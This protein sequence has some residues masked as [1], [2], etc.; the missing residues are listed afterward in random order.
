M[1]ARIIRP[2]GSARWLRIHAAVRTSNGRATH[3]YGMK[4]DV[5]EDRARLDEMRRLA[6]L[7]GLTGLPGRTPFQRDFL[8]AAP[9]ARGAVAVA[10]ALVLIDV[11]GF[12][13]VN[14]RQGHDAGDA[15]LRAV[16]SRLT[17][18]F[19][20]ARLIARIGGDEFALVIDRG[21]A[22][23]DVATGARLEARMGR[24]LQWIA[25]P[26]AWRGQ[27]LRVSASAGIAY[28]DGDNH[29]SAALFTAADAALYAA[30]RSGRNAYRV[31]RRIAWSVF[32]G[33]GPIR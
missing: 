1:E 27:V 11:D 14:D 23:G 26:V 20:D 13:Q 32:E 6:E 4:Q 29:D 31:Q 12:K 16:A 28:R 33:D 7:D 22:P 17:A 25:R 10:D 21:T 30:K 15:C 8:D 9:G 18:A 3:L 19:P 5:S 24:A 2:D